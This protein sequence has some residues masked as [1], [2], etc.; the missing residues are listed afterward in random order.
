ML[1]NWKMREKEKQGSWT[2]STHIQTTYI[3]YSNTTTNCIPPTVMQISSCQTLDGNVHLQ[4]NS[5][6]ISEATWEIRPWCNSMIRGMVKSNWEAERKGLKRLS[7][8][9]IF[10]L[11]AS[12]WLFMNLNTNCAHGSWTNEEETIHY[13][14]RYVYVSSTNRFRKFSFKIA[15][16]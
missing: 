6:C 16:E 12:T 11:Y 10:S 13:Q 8:C 3:K 1:Y 9:S 14:Q 2:L 4:L 7:G 15:L 5:W